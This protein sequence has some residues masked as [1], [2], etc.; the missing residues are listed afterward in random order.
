MSISV[1]INYCTNDYRF[2]SKAIEG[3]RP[4]AKNII[5]PVSDHFFD[6]E[7]ENRHLLELSYHQHPDCQFVE[8][9]FDENCPYGLYAPV[10]KGDPDW[11]HFWHSTNRYIGYH[12]VPK[13][14]D[15]ILFIDVDEIFDEKRFAEWLSFFPYQEYSALKF[16]SYFYFRSA[17]FRAHS[18]HSNGPLMI[19]RELIEPECLLDL[20]ERKGIFV[21]FPGAKLDHVKGL[22]DKPLCHHYSWVK[23]KEELFRKVVSWGHYQDKNWEALLEEEFRQPFRG[24]DCLF[25]LVYERVEP[26]WDPL[27]VNIPKRDNVSLVNPAVVRRLNVDL[28]FGDELFKP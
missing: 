6:G 1:V 25:G 23:P 7:K 24:K 21:D 26:L 27:S 15:Y 13:E 9:S 4:F 17:S 12:F 19:K 3:V 11:I 22:D 20:C 18:M 10:K 14:T 28:V 2:L 16:S 8:F 5:I